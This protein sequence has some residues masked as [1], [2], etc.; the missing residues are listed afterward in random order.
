ME[1]LQYA[2]HQCLKKPLIWTVQVSPVNKVQDVTTAE[3]LC[4]PLQVAFCTQQHKELVTKGKLNATQLT[5]IASFPWP[6]TIH[7]HYTNSNL[8]FLYFFKDAI[9]NAETWDWCRSLSIVT[10]KSGNQRLR[11]LRTHAATLH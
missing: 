10:G 9:S 11:S 2:A 5:H 8:L 3:L 6:P 4:R 1:L 7:K